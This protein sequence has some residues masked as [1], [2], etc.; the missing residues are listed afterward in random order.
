MTW[1]RPLQRGQARSTAKKPCWAR[2]RP[3]PLQVS[4][5]L[6]EAPG[7]APEPSQVSQL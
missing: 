7:L 4:Q 5:V 3:W 2:T 6:G 1:P